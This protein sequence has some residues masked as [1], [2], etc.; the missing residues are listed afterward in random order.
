MYKVFFKDR[1][2]FLTDNFAEHFQVKYGLFYKLRDGGDLQEL[3][4]FYSNLKSIDSLYLFH[5]DID[6]LREEFRKCFT[7]IPAAGGLVTNSKGEFLLIH[8]KGK[9][10]LPKGKLDRGESVEAAA[11]REV[12]EECGIQG[13]QLLEPLVATYHTYPY[14]DGTALKKIV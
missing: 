2:V 7:L 11:V 5:P 12:E 3:L 10:D 13:V 9:W 8:R 1:K 4:S 14:K 6:Y